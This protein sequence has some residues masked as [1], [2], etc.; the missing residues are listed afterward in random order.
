MDTVSHFAAFG[1]NSSIKNIINA[2]KVRIEVAMKMNPMAVNAVKVLRKI[3]SFFMG[4]SYG[5]LIG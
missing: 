2:G 1:F 3:S 4:V 5:Y